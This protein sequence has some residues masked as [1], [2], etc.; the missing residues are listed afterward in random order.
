MHTVRLSAKNSTATIDAV[1][2][3]VGTI[4]PA[5]LRQGLTIVVA[6][7]AGE[8]LAF[9][10]RQQQQQQRQQQRWC[11]RYSTA[12]SSNCTVQHSTASG[13]TA[14]A[15]RETGLPL[16]LPTTPTTLSPLHPPRAIRSMALSPRNSRV[17]ELDLG[18]PRIHSG[19]AGDYDAHTVLCRLERSPDE[20]TEHVFAVG[21]DV[22]RGRACPPYVIQGLLYH[23]LERDGCEGL[24]PLQPLMTFLRCHI[25]S[26]VLDFFSHDLM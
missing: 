17:S 20:E 24:G 7:S 19:P 2:L 23:E 26:N 5:A 8:V 22:V 11:R 15:A 13:S 10:G 18:F 4:A 21:S 6:V 12:Q 25:M 9:C 16:S 14:Q 3:G 1:D